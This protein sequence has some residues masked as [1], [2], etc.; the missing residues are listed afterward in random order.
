MLNE[1]EKNVVIMDNGEQT[2]DSRGLS[3]SG[4]G[5][6]FWDK[7][8][9]IF[10]TEAMFDPVTLG[11]GNLLFAFD[12]WI[13]SF[14]YGNNFAA[15]GK[16]VGEYQLGKQNSHW[17]EIV[18]RFPADSDAK[19]RLISAWGVSH[20]MDLRTVY[21]GEYLA[22]ISIG[23]VYPADFKFVVFGRDG[24]K[25]SAT[26]LFA[27]NAFPDALMGKD[28]HGKPLYGVD[29]WAGGGLRKAWR[30]SARCT[31]RVSFHLSNQ[32]W[33]VRKQ[34]PQRR[35]RVDDPD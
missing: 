18:L 12:A 22:H 17:G 2:E 6:V 35:Q 13:A 32:A 10:G 31:G 8:T 4:K 26:E 9:M 5:L 33:K 24:K 34:L 21:D 19:T 23:N 30:A 1:P 7:G 11:R 29:Q 14:T 16:K 20:S 27:K 25:I 15:S 3:N 28:K